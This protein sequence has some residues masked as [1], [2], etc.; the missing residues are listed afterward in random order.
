MPNYTAT[1][2]WDRDDAPFTDQRYSRAHRW[3]FD[4]GLEVPASASPH[5]VRVPLSDPAAVDP[6]EAFV[7]SLS[8]CHML[9]FLYVAARRGIVVERYEDEAEGT[10]HENDEGRQ[11]ITRVVLRP[12]VAYGSAVDVDTDASMHHE[13]HELCY[14]ANSVRSE[15]VM[16]PRIV[17]PPGKVPAGA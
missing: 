9:Y 15:I 10:M 8:S 2:T 14:L 16:E 12:S 17:Q 1:I 5:H 13:A 6:E 7:A 11:A 4:G 3:R